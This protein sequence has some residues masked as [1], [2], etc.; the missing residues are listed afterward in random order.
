MNSEVS[1]LCVFR[2]VQK[3]D[4]SECYKGVLRTASLRKAKREEVEL[5][6]IASE[7]CNEGFLDAF[8]GGGE[9][10]DL[11][12]FGE[13]GEEKKRGRSKDS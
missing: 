6:L 3:G 12:M 4:G 10:P 5:T 13:V 2:K 8:R 7:C 1:I 9:L 11:L